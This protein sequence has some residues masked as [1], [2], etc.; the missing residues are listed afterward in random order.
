MTQ[1]VTSC[2]HEGTF[3]CEV[4]VAM[5]RVSRVYNTSESSQQPDHISDGLAR[6]QMMPRA[7]IVNTTCLFQG[8]KWAAFSVAVERK[9]HLTQALSFCGGDQTRHSLYRDA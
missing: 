7:F 9:L 3:Y 5:I 6:K 4:I 1:R 8:T 2:I